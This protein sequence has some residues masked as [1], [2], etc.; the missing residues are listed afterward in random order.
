MYWRV[1]GTD[2]TVAADMATPGWLALGWS[3]SGSM[4]VSEAVIGN[5]VHTMATSN[6]Q[7]ASFFMINGYSLSAIRLDSRVSLSNISVTTIGGR[8]I[9]RWGVGGSRSEIS[10]RSLPRSNLSLSRRG[11]RSCICS[12]SALRGSMCSHT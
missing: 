9:M 4:I 6:G 11:S 12:C 1:D 5:H 3:L 10:S 7:A 2:I 8:T